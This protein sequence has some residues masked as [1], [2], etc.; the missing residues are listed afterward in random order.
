MTEQK[1]IP[2]ENIINTLKGEVKYKD[3]YNTVMAL[4]FHFRG[5]IQGIKVAGGITQKEREQL[6]NYLRD[7]V[8]EKVLVCSEFKWFW[9][10]PHKHTKKCY[11]RRYKY[12]S[13]LK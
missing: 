8:T 10:K 4:D 11:T 9:Q 1:K 3:Y 12:W 13:E 2:M 5:I 7:M 6:N